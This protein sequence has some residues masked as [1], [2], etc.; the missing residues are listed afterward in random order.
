MQKDLVTV[1]PT[2]IVFDAAV[3]MNEYHV[4]SVLIVMG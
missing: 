3:K 4:G 2:S 1:L